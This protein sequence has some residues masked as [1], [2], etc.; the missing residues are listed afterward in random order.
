MYDGNISLPE[1]PK[2][3]GKCPSCDA[4]VSPA[5]GR[6]MGDACPFC[7]KMLHRKNVESNRGYGRKLF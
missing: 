6:R 3:N 5:F 4:F 7:K 2:W 1:L